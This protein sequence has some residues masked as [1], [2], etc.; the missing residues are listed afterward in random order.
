M[1]SRAIVLL[2]VLGLVAASC[3]SRTSSSSSST[4]TSAASGTAA[5]TSGVPTDP[6]A[7]CG[8]G[9][10]HGATAPGV[11]DTEIHIATIQDISGPVPGL[12]LGNQQ[13]MKAFEAYCNSLGGINGRKLVFDFLDSGLVNSRA[14]FQQACTSFAL[15]GEMVVFD[16]AESEPA[17]TCGIPDV[18]AATASTKHAIRP[19]VVQPLPLPPNT[20]NIGPGRYIAKKYPSAISK[21]AMWYVN[22]STT[23]AASQRQVEGYKQIGFN[24]LINSQIG[25]V[26]TGWQNLVD[27]MRQK[28]IQYVYVQ[29]DVTNTVGMLNELKAQGIHVQVLDGGQAQYTPDLLSKGGAAAEGMYVTMTTVPFE[30]ASSTPELQIF[31]H[32]LDQVSPDATPTALGVFGWS[33]GL[34]FATAAKALGSN[35]T[36]QGLMD[37]LHSIHAWNGHGLHGESNPGSNAPSPCFMY[38]QVQHGKFV[39]AYPSKGFDC[40][41]DNIA[42]LKGDYVSMG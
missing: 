8:P 38:L 20:W 36:R 28:D 25:V 19:N 12:F 32:W 35:V 27:Q 39:R 17:Q 21:A 26:E 40:S 22:A 29:S 9:D 16:G 24:W 13:A 34:L 31:L 41:P 42:V 7:P 1:R 4:S 11:T 37:Q 15:V 6:N 3:G 5:T 18:A 30:E 23:L 2:C 10:A 14:M 33:A